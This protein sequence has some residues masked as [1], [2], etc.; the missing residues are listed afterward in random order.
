MSNTANII[1]YAK[2]IAIYRQYPRLE[3]GLQP[4]E[5][6]TENG[7]FYAGLN[8]KYQNEFMEMRAAWADQQIGKKTIWH[9]FHEVADVYYY[10]KQIE[11][12]SGQ[13][14]WPIVYSG[15]RI[16][17]P[18]EYGEREVELA[19]DAKYKFRSSGP[20]NKDESL[21]LQL[22]QEAI[23]NT[24]R[25]GARS[26]NQYARKDGPGRT[27]SLYLPSQTRLKLQALLE[28]RGIEASPIEEDRLARAL[29]RLAIDE[30]YE[31]LEN[32]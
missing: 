24:P 20:N 22:I 6:Y 7:E 28:K 23:E 17:L 31:R 5:D 25:R 4:L 14:L 26:G 8:T 15:L 2:Q 21:E 13:L 11:T 19:A 1:D 3:N 9:V 30:E 18:M 16:Y 12:Q 10:S 32:S 29:F 27:T